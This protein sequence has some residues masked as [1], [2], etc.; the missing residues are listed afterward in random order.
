MRRETAEGYPSG[1]GLGG[2]A[3][4]IGFQKREEH[5]RATALGRAA[6]LLFEALKIVD[7]LN[8]YPEIGARLNDMIETM[9][10][11]AGLV[12]MDDPKW[13]DISSNRT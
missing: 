8:D 10:A 11:E 1:L 5:L 6:Q 7:E 4:K 2:N 9:R 12:L 13:T 3:L